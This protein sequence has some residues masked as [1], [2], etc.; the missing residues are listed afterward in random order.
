MQP[1]Q[2]VRITMFG[3]EGARYLLSVDFSEC[4]NGDIDFN[5]DCD[6][7]A[8][9]NAQCQRV[10]VCGDGLV[11]AP[12]T[13]DDGNTQSGDLC[14]SSCQLEFTNGTLESEPNDP[15]LSTSPQTTPTP[16]GPI[17]V[18]ATQFFL[19]SLNPRGDRDVYLIENPT[20]EIQGIRL[21]T[22]HALLGAE[23][24]C[25]LWLQTSLNVFD[26]FGNSIIG[27]G[28]NDGCSDLTFS[29]QPQQRAF[30]V[31][32]AEGALAPGYLLGV[33]SAPSLCG[34][35]SVEISASV[36]ACDDGNNISGDGC[37]SDCQ[38]ELGTR[39]TE[40][41]DD[42]SPSTGG[43]PEG[44]DFS[45]ANANGPITEDAIFV[46]T[47]NPQGDEDVFAVQNTSG[48]AVTVRVDT[49]GRNGLN[50]PCDSFIQT[51]TILTIRDA[52]GNQ[53][54]QNDNRATPA[55]LCSGLSFEILAG[56]T[57]FVHV[58][59]A[60]DIFRFPY[61]LTVNFPGVCGDGQQDLFFEQCDDGNAV[62]GDGCSDSC[63]LEFLT[64]G[65]EPGQIL[66]RF[67]ANDVPVSIPDNNLV[68][69]T[70]TISVNDNRVIERVIVTIES[71]THTFTGDLDISLVSPSGASFFLADSAGASG[72]NFTN[73]S[74]D[75]NCQSP[76][77]T[78]AA[79]FD[80]CFKPVGALA[81]LQGQSLQG[82]W[83]L[84][85]VDTAAQDVGTIDGWNIGFCVVGVAICGD[86]DFQ[87]GTEQCDD[88][89]LIDG[90]GCSAL[91]QLE[92]CG[93]NVVQ[94]NLGETCDDA[95]GINNDGCDND[96][97]HRADLTETEP[98]DD[99]AI[100][101]GGLG[102]DGNDFSSANANGP[103]SQDT[104]LFAS[105]NPAGDEDVFA[106]TNSGIASVTVQLDVFSA[107]LGLGAACDDS[108]DTGLN[109]RDAAGALIAQNDD[110][111][112]QDRCSG[113]SI[114]LAPG[115]TIFAHLTEFKDDA[116]IG[117]YFF[118]ID[119]Q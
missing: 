110:R 84:K 57:L 44:N 102:I 75:D 67:D 39:E 29:L 115:D 23:Q 78:G 46:G 66:V 103:F 91:C 95:N 9:C 94:P 14:S 87:A 19:G 12:E 70:S 69:A 49:F 114:T 99:G 24:D 72:D 30:V 18:G 32:S 21:E 113:L 71:L 58:A 83:R 6:G 117:G 56:Q 5:E 31:V 54:A 81:S 88:G 62:S 50:N 90:D 38:F 85:A 20:N 74:F 27:G 10:A 41:N 63:Q 8:G 52:A 2:S 116:V 42:G 7:G 79:P 118:V 55:D 22:F 109:L 16:D 26:S 43:G 80:G 35:F 65:C 40:P 108:A 105:L 68:G 119:F 77:N 51:D 45:A 47:I 60:A 92:Q 96:C 37:S 86:G 93:D 104:T 4:G 15:S 28:A 13:C 89:N 73:T 64:D 53:L 61:I 25:S 76:I 34:N 111:S 107:S 98:N 82:S 33:S 100:S 48:A 106:I 11:D 101:L 97:I 1:G 3:E 36:E 112:A 59:D 17:I